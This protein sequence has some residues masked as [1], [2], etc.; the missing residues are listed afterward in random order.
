MEGRLLGSS[1]AISATAAL[2][3]YLLFPA[4]GQIPALNVTSLMMVTLSAVLDGLNAG[5]PTP[6]ISGGCGKLTW[7]LEEG[8]RV[9]FGG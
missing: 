9:S 2:Y 6:R 3:P 5:L 4:K 7:E 1:I 8:G